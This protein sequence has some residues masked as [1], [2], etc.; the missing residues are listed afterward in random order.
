MVAVGVESQHHFTMNRQTPL[1]SL[2]WLIYA[3]LKLSNNLFLYNNSK[4]NLVYLH[5]FYTQID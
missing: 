5:H 1:A 2:M 4:P 3:E